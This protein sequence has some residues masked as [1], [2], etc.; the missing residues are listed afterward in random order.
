MKCQLKKTVRTLLIAALAIALANCASSSATVNQT[1]DLHTGVTV[2]YVQTPLVL[3][4]ENPMRAAFARNYVYLGPIEVNDSGS[5][6]YFLWFG[7]WDTMQSSD[8]AAHRDGF[9]S[10][11]LFVD[12]EPLPLEL[13]GWAPSSIGLQSEVYA[14]PVAASADAFYRVT[15]DQIRLLAE[16]RD[17][18]LNVTGAL[19]REFALWDR[20]LTASSNL[21]DFMTQANR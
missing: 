3:F 10:V 7:I 5:Y 11:V 14:A 20:Q 19:P 6:E 12:D 9:E 13:V 21:Q 17:I 16:A 4:R 8:E 15:L 2:S 18:R 1:L